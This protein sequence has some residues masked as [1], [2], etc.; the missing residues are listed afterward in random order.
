MPDIIDAAKKE[1]IRTF[2]EVFTP[3]AIVEDMLDM[4]EGK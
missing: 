2:G 3:P 1:R 4:L